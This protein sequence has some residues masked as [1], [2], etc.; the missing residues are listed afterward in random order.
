[1]HCNLVV[2]VYSACQFLLVADFNLRYLRLDNYNF[3][4]NHFFLWPEALS[5]FKD[6]FCDCL[7]ESITRCLY[8]RSSY[9]Q[10]FFI[11]LEGNSIQISVRINFWLQKL[12]CLYLDL[13]ILVFYIVLIGWILPLFWI[14]LLRKQIYFLRWVRLRGNCL[15]D[16]CDLRLEFILWRYSH[17]VTLK[18][19]NLSKRLLSWGLSFWG[20]C[21]QEFLGC[22]KDF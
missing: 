13:Q 17:I 8:R 1:M 16:L 4:T 21:L 14:K 7:I 5:I 19:D 3:I 9:R 2:S 10:S 18:R 6:I 12:P 22:L 15:C 20:N 11:F